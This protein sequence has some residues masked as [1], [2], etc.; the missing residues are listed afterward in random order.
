MFSVTNS[1]SYLFDQACPWRLVQDRIPATLHRGSHFDHKLKYRGMIQSWAHCCRV[2][3]TN[4]SWAN[5][6]EI[7]NYSRFSTC[8]TRSLGIDSRCSWEWKISPLY[9]Y[10]PLLWLSWTRCHWLGGNL[11]WTILRS[12]H[13]WTELLGI[14]FKVRATPSL[15]IFIMLMGKSVEWD[16]E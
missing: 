6:W 7:H 4:H 13:R 14:Y 5:I 1:S 8:R 12:R 11:A 3:D 16:H 9:M 2:E 10:H 15:F